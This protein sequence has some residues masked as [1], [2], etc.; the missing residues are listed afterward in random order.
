MLFE[1]LLSSSRQVSWLGLSLRSTCRNGEGGSGILA[2]QEL[3]RW[4]S[5]WSAFWPSRALRLQ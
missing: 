5:M 3:G 4:T 2:L 1:H